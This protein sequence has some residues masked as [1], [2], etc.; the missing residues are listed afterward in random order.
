MRPYVIR[1]GDYLTKLAHVMGFD[2]T[3]VWN[4]PKNEALR[5]KRPDWNLLYPGDILWVPSGPNH[6]RLPI[7]AGGHNRYI[8]RIPRVFVALRITIGGE[9]L[10]KEPFR[11]LGLGDPVEGETDEKGYLHAGLPVHLREIEVLLPSRDRTLRLRVGDLD[12]VDTVGGLKKRLMHLGYYQPTRIGVENEVADGDALVSALKSFQADKGIAPSGKLDDATR[13][14]LTG[15]H[16][17]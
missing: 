16:G 10:T 13:E 12:P 4:D 8:A 7:R 6:R 2:A 14:G 3:T 17:S 11:I 9:P 5:E 1:Q 15:D